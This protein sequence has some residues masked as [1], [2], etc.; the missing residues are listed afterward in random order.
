MYNLAH[1]RQPSTISQ[2]PAALS[3]NATALGKGITDLYHNTTEA[4][5]DHLPGFGPS[6]EEKE[7]ATKIDWINKQLNKNK[8]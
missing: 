4:I 5:G 3:E 8:Q 1:E 6:N 2:F 7:L